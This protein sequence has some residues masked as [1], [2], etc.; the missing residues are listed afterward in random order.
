M[1]KELLLR[2]LLKSGRPTAFYIMSRT[3]LKSAAIVVS[4][5]S[6]PPPMVDTMLAAC[7]L[8]KMS[9]FIIMSD[10]T[11]RQTDGLTDTGRFLRLPQDVTSVIAQ[12]NAI[13]RVEL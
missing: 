3:T 8:P 6:V 5:E 4:A 1:L 12:Y 13:S 2:L 10:R 7:L 11:D 9:H